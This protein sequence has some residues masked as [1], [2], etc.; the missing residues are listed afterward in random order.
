VRVLFDTNVLISSLLFPG[1]SGEVAL[2]RI[3][4]GR[5]SLIISKPLLHE[6]LTVLAHKFSHDREELARVAV[7]LD[8]IAEMIHPQTQ[9]Q[10]LEDDP[11]NRV[12]ECAIAGKADVIVTGDKAILH[13][14]DYQHIR[15]LSLKDYLDQT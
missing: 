11:D 5:D 12:L 2:F 15:I 9:L 1:G 10:V 14:R 8:D 13:L 7:L 4:E 6:L 3:I